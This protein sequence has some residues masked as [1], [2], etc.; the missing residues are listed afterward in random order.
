MEMQSSMGWMIPAWIL[1]APLVAG[2]IAW[3]AAPKTTTL[4]DT[5]VY[6]QGTR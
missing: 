3:F 5:T 2:L 4:R 1:G 6:P